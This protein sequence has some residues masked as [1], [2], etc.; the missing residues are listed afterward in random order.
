MIKVLIVDDSAVVRQ[1]LARGLS[2]DP[3]IC[4]V[5]TAVDPYVARDKI[6]RLFPD[7]L[8]LDIEMPRM[9]GITFLEKLMRHH[10]LPVVVVSS[11]TQEGSNLALRA[12][13]LG[14]VEVVS[15]ESASLD[16]RDFF[17]WVREK[18]KAAAKADMGKVIA[19]RE[20]NGMGLDKVIPVPMAGTP[21]KIVAIGASTGGTNALR[22]MLSLFPPNGPAT[23][24]V[25]HMPELFT[26][27]FA[28]NLDGLCSIEVKE[29]QDGDTVRP[30]LALIAPGNR[31]MVLKKNGISYEIKVKYGPR[32]NHQRPSVDV[33]FS[34]VA[35]SAGS[36]SLGVLLTGMGRDGA[37]G[38]RMMRDAG[39][40]TIA[41]DEAT[42]VVYGMPKA[43][44]ELGAAK[45]VLPLSS[46]LP[47]LLAA[48]K[49]PSGS[50]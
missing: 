32:V 45:Y 42:S 4:V 47:K 16:T 17:K 25:Q 1:A 27:Y 30:G 3:S 34:S 40:E 31:H 33:L 15:K 38:L 8:T 20:M 48:V 23:V 21:K 28:K 14:A 19:D 46:I 29:A 36:E 50:R 44:V 43:A 10:P 49:S 12:L 37:S 39:A 18:V 24:I 9:N 7:V 11:F 35:R 5:G 13:E 6:L 26:G 41:Q 2:K 22:D